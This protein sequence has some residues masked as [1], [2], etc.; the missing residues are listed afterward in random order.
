MLKGSVRA[1]L[2]STVLAATS[3]AG[4][5]VG[6]I[7]AAAGQLTVV[8]CRGNPIALQPAINSAAPGA[9]LLVSG[10]C[11]GPFT[12]TKDLTLIGLKPAV[13]D[14]NKAGSTVT[15]TGAVRVRLDTL[16][17][18]NGTGSGIRNNGG[19]LDLT[20]STVEHNTAGPG[21]GI[22]NDV[23]G[24]V[25]LTG[26]TVRDNTSHSGGGIINFGTVRLTG[27]TVEHNTSTID[28]GGIYNNFNGTAT[29]TGSTVRHNT[30]ARAGG[31]I[32]N[33]FNS[34]VT[35]TSST[36]GGNTTGTVGGGIWN[37]INSTVTLIGSTVG[38]NTAET[39]GGGVYNKDGT[40]TLTGS[41]VR[42]N[43]PDNC[44]GPVPVPGCTG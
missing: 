20:G 15:V 5:L 13:L 24:T 33:I 25:T 29:L 6:A 30:A 40:V 44:G 3:G 7:P 8:D 16:T 10:T 37:D 2:S 34:R 28:G 4:G 36:V 27:S 22:Y 21:G 9:A 12:I 41:T 39:E 31:G 32:Y 18:T 26:S 1:A 23:N 11:T 14:G 17:I 38:D 42:N 19:T 35:L 43:R